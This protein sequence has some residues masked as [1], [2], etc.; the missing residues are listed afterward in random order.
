MYLLGPCTTEDMHSK[1]MRRW[2]DINVDQP[3][4]HRIHVEVTFDARVVDDDD[5]LNEVLDIPYGREPYWIIASPLPDGTVLVDTTD[6]YHTEEAAQAAF[7]IRLAGQAQE[8]QAI[9]DSKLLGLLRSDTQLNR[10]RV[11]F[12]SAAAEIEQDAMQRRPSSPIDIRKMEFA[13]VARILAE[14]GIIPEIPTISEG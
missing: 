10:A 7:A 11:R 12:S 13:A 4:E 6:F 8:I 5:K 1:C 3:Y 14:F 2:F 9:S